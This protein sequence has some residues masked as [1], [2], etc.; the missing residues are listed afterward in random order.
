MVFRQMI[1]T[2]IGYMEIYRIIINHIIKFD[3]DRNVKQNG[4]IN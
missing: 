3:T 2:N 4:K 1:V